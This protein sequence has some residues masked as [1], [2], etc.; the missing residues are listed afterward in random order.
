M[1][2][3]IV[4][5]IVFPLQEF[6]KGKPTLARL[7]EL[8]KSQ[9]FS[10]EQMRALQ[11]ERLRQLLSFAYKQVPYYRELFDDHRIVPDQIRSLKDLSRIPTLEKAVIRSRFDDLHPQLLPGRVQKMST[12]GSTGSPVTILVDSERA[13][14]TDAARMRAH[15]W[16]DADMG[17]REVVLWGSPIELGGQ[18]KIKDL[19]DW[20]I[21]SHLL[22]AFDMSESRMLMYGEYIARYRPVKMYGY[23]SALYLLAAC[24]KKSG[25]KP[26]QDLKVIFATAEPLFDFQRRMVE[27]VFD[28]AV[29]A[30]YGARDAGLMA[31]EC[32]QGGLHIPAEGTLIEIDSPGGGAGEI[33]ATNLFSKAMPIIRYRTGDIGELDDEPCACRRGLPR[34]RHVQGRQTDFL[35]TPSGKMVHALAV[36]YAIREMPAIES[37]QVLQDDLMD[38]LIR[39]VTKPEFSNVDEKRLVAKTAAA[40]GEGVHISVEKVSAI[41]TAPSGKFRYVISKA[42]ETRLASFTKP[43]DSQIA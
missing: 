31:N 19:R 9:W 22:S 37:F 4:R 24:L 7:I 29:S 3:A 21:N 34:L 42:A 17:E 28:C 23:A 41:P 2:P 38:V 18:G 1:H 16:Y 12:G 25:W 33:I 27:E 30:E 35:V 20:L 32:P 39:I 14:F 15:R 5:A 13:A 6:A 10:R 8:E 36:I 40:L 43:N 11:L 26:P